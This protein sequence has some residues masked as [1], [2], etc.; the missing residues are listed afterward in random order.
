MPEINIKLVVGLGNPGDKYAY[1]RHN[2]GFLVI[3]ALA[4]KLELS[5]KRSGS[6]EIC[7]FNRFGRNHRTAEAADIYESLR[8]SG[9][10][11]G[12]AI[13]ARPRGI[14]GAGG[15]F[16]T[17]PLGMLR[18]RGERIGWRAQWVDFPLIEHCRRAYPS[19]RLRF[20]VGPLP[21]RMDPADF[22]LHRFLDEE[23]EEVAANGSSPE[24]KRCNSAWHGRWRGDEMR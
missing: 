19:R 18:V 8:R 17:L 20:G 11:R 2:A 9:H 15:R 24:S 6:A 3:D 13:A 14:T 10:L 4:R 16:R 21:E 22:V 12:A 5:W 1:T 23:S 7:S